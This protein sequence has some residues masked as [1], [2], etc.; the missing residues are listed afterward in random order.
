MTV[1]KPAKVLVDCSN[2]IGMLN[3]YNQKIESNLNQNI[4]QDNQD[5]EIA[6][7]FNKDFCNF[8]IEFQNQDSTE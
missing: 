5:S 2:L 4:R 6:V 8:T 7:N 1:G 3:E